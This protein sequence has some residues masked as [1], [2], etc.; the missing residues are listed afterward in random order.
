MLETS[1]ILAIN[2]LDRYIAIKYQVTTTF[3]AI[4][5]NNRNVITFTTGQ[6]LPQLGATL[7]ADGIPVGTTITAVNNSVSNP[8]LLGTWDDDF[9]LAFIF[10]GEP[11]VGSFLQGEYLDDPEGQFDLDSIITNVVPFASSNGY[12]VLLE[13]NTYNQS[14][15][16]NQF[17]AIWRF[18]GQPFIEY[19]AGPLPSIGDAIYNN[20]LTVIGLVTNVDLAQNV[21]D[22]NGV[23]QDIQSFPQVVYFRL[24]VPIQQTTDIV[25]ISKN[26]TNAQP[27]PVVVTQTFSTS[28]PQ[29]PTSNALAAAYKD[30]EPYCNNF[31]I[32]SPGALI[33]G[34]I[35]GIIVSQT[36]L[37]YNIPT[38]NRGKNDTFVIGVGGPVYIDLTIPYGFYYADELAATIQALIAGNPT[39]AALN[40]T[41]TFSPRDGFVF[42][43]V[44]GTPFYFPDPTSYINR[45]SS[46]V[47]NLLKTYRLLGITI[48][49]SLPAVVQISFD[50][51]N[52]LYTP[53][54]DIYSK[55]LTNYQYIKDTNT[56]VEKP[57]GLVARIYVSGTGQI[58]TTGS[59]SAL[60]TA[61]FVMTSDLN[62]PKVIKW[63]PD[64]AVP[65]IDFQLLDQYGDLIPGADQ[66]FSTEFQMT[67]LCIEGGQ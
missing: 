29:A 26:T 38:I 28:N 41:V 19:V 20:T 18:A 4:W 48:A 22:F 44:S 5:A 35:K 65:S 27:V 51:P 13:N 55:N 53:Y 12:S 8:P 7:L 31:R 66:G 37:Q 63:S 23:T 15:P 36:Q 9:T 30:S 32:E 21:I 33:Y 40:M 54:I 10:R 43:S 14:G 47:N 57:S 17:Q 6:P 45:D 59:T 56:S 61:P 67:L 50:Y 60:G 64:V 11:I 62:T 1:A 3:N 46:Y 25:I 39:L 34:Y 49:N 58:Q 42:T 16:R 2:S 24:P 52:F